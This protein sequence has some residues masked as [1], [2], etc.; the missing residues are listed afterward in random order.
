MD[1]SPK[2][3]EIKAKINK[4]ILIKLKRF[5]TARETINKMKRQPIEWEKIFANNTTDKGLIHKIQTAHT[6]QYQKNT[7]NLIKKMCRKEGN[8]K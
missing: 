5:C 3:K 2:A 6:T 8:H 4:W 7:N 1:L